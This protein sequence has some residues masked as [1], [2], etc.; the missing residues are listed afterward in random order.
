MTEHLRHEPYQPEIIS[1]EKYKSTVEQHNQKEVYDH[2]ENI[3]Q[4]NE[5]V[6]TARRTVEK[7]ALT[8]D[9]L[10]LSEESTK[11]NSYHYVTKKIKSE[12]YN[13]TLDHLRKHLSPTNQIFSKLIHKPVVETVSEIGSKTIARPSGILGGGLL[14]LSGG[15]FIFVIAKKI[16]FSMPASLFIL[17]FL[18]GFLIGVLIEFLL[19]VARRRFN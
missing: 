14:A 4:Q 17:L 19:K 1:N 18:I 7:H 2:K 9:V 8:K 12:R 6:E 10:A 16:G 11:T 13:F 5:T 3:N 15:L